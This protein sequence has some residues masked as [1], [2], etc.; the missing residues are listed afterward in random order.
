MNDQLERIF[1]F[2]ALQRVRAPASRDA[3]EAVLAQTVKGTMKVM[4]ANGRMP[5]PPPGLELD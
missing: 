2:M 5:P 3:A 4:L 1:E